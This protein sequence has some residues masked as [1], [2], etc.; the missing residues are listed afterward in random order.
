MTDWVGLSEERLADDA[1][2]VVLAERMQTLVAT[3]ESNHQRPM[4]GTDLVACLAAGGRAV[5]HSYARALLTGRRT[6]AS[7]A[8]LTA[9]AAMF[10]VEVSFFAAPREPGIPRD[11]EEVIAGLSCPS[12]RYLLRAA[13]GLSPASQ[14]LLGD[15][16]GRLR[17]VEGRSPD[18][19]W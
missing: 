19:E 6:T 15:M 7:P 18:T 17:I 5:S 1:S 9:L 14:A 11:A 16:A 4:T 10:G 3:W 12:L 13:V 2:A 8:V